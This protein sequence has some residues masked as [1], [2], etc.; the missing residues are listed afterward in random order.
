MVAQRFF[1]IWAF[2]MLMS[3]GAM[4]QS[5]K[6]LM[7]QGIAHYQIDEFEK[8]LNYFNQAVALDSTDLDIIGRRGYVCSRY[9][10]AIELGRVDKPAPADYNEL[11]SK[12]IL[13]LKLSL[14]KFPDNQEN[15]RSLRF[16]ESKKP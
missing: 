12:G 4:A 9:V 7:R 2:I 16:L 13:D 15:Q 5:A 14:A 8:S 1:I 11:I 3:A 6:E 10:M